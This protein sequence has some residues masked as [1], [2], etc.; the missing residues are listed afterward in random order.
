MIN[1]PNKKK[2]DQKKEVI[3]AANRRMD[4]E[5]AINISNSFYKSFYGA[6]CL[7]SF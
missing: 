1:Y 4:F 2:V 6:F 3:N 5:H 7:G